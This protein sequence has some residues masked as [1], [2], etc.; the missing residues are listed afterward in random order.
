MIKLEYFTHKDFTQLME[1]VADEETLMNWSG[2]LFSFPL[3]QSS[4]EWYIED[5]ND[6][7]NSDAF[8]YKAIETSTGKVVGHIS[9]GSISKKNK[10]GRISRVLVAP[11][12]QGKGYCRQMV[13]AVLKIGF[14]E[15]ALHRICLGVYDFNKAAISCYKKAGLMIEGT[16]RDC[17]LFKDKWWSL[18]E[19]SILEEEWKDEAK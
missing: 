1:W 4:L 9:L 12:H 3:R 6:L 2:A 5:V 7:E 11:A 18:V 13:S 8:I 10:A 16:N 15:L 17:L 14:E 19:M